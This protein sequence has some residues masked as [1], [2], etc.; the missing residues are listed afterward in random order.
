MPCGLVN[1]EA[2]DDAEA[3]Q[4]QNDHVDQK[5]KAMKEKSLPT[6]CSEGKMK[7]QRIDNEEKVDGIERMK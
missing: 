5:L 7:G 4:R 6:N 2:L 1:W 3:S